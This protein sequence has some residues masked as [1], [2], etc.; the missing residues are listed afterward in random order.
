MQQRVPLWMQNTIIFFAL[1]Y[2]TLTMATLIYVPTMVEHV[3]ERTWLFIVP[4][5]TM[6]AIANIPRSVYH[7]QPGRAFFSSCLAVLALWLLVGIGMYPDL[8]IGDPESTS[9]TIHNS[10]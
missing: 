7:N 6:L 4:I 3:K 10:A 5:L 9:L 8:V 1:C 2:F